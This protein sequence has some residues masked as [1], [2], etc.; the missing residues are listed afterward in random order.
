[1][2]WIDRERMIV[3]C[4]AAGG[5]TRAPGSWFSWALVLAAVRGLQPGEVGAGVI[6]FERDRGKGGRALVFAV[7]FGNPVDDPAHRIKDG[8]K[9]WFTAD[10][11]GIGHAR[12]A[13]VEIK[14]A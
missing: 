1:M 11:V 10:G 12:R 7:R 9:V 2:G 4:I 13:R 6:A 3:S 14:P 8:N 5:D